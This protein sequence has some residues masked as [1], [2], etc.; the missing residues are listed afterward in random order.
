[1]PSN[2][3]PRPARKSTPHNNTTPQA[4]ISA[5]NSV[6]HSHQTMTGSSQPDWQRS[7]IGITPVT[8]R[9]RPGSRRVKKFDVVGTGTAR[10]EKQAIGGAQVNIIFPGIGDR[11]GGVRA[12]GGGSSG[13]RQAAAGRVCSVCTRASGDYSCPRCLIRYCSSKCYKVRHHSSSCLC[14]TTSSVCIR[15]HHLHLFST[16]FPQYEAFCCHICCFLVGCHV[17]YKG[18]GAGAT[19]DHCN[20][21]AG[22][23]AS[24]WLRV[25]ATALQWVSEKREGT[26]FC[27]CV[28]VGAQQLNNSSYQ[29]NCPY[30]YCCCTSSCTLRTHLVPFSDR[31]VPGPLHTC[32][33]IRTKIFFHQRSRQGPQKHKIIPLRT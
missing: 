28:S 8:V 22:S 10:A 9:P 32:T 6:H 26:L 23:A 3:N 24:F 27:C 33:H 14:A 29:Y 25:R 30:C 21:S 20:K 16:N 12:E 19:A 31:T 13:S 7:S 5:A 4:L 18:G 1:M 2:P 11:G 15:Q 17:I